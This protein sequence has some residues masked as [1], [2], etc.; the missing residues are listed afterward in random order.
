MVSSRADMP[1]LRP[2][3]PADGDAFAALLARSAD[4]GAFQLSSRFRIPP[5]DALRA[6]HGTFDGVVA[7]EPGT[8]GLVGCG[9]VRFMRAHFEGAVRDV[10]LLNTLVVDPAHRRKGIASALAAWRVRHARERVGPDGVVFAGIQMGNVGS[11]KTAARWATQTLPGVVGVYPT[12]P[13]RTS[14]KR[15]DGLRVR[16]AEP[17]DYEAFA[18]HLDASCGDYDFFPPENAGTLS[19]WLSETPVEGPFRFAYVI[20]DAAGNLVAGLALS[21]LA[22]IRT[23]RILRMPR[24]T[25][26]LNHV[27]RIFPR[28]GHMREASTSRFWYRPGAERAAVR[29]WEVLRW[30][31]RERASTFLL[32]SDPR[33]PL[34]TLMKPPPWMPKSTGSLV[35][36]APVPWDPAR[37]VYPM[38]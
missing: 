20:E 18:A 3:T 36:A 14:P 27:I 10:A 7:E 26:L 6:L 12:P 28:D 22:R 8:P 19:A 15:S 38:M 32:W 34:A 16:E 13:R 1:V 17:R 31:W 4:A 35:L 25:S 2:I 30:E 21:E 33:A 37:F 29:L 11:V 23:T 9:L 24:V 5:W